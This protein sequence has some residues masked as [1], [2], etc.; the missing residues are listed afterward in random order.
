M[1]LHILEDNDFNSIKVYTDLKNKLSINKTKLYTDLYFN[2][3]TILA[4]QFQN[5]P[6]TRGLPLIRI[7]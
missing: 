6:A 5:T 4:A 7:T 2:I 3:K 1:R